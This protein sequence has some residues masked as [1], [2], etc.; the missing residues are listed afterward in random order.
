[1]EFDT[2]VRDDCF[3]VEGTSLINLR[4]TD[5]FYAWSFVLIGAN[6]LVSR[7]GFEWPLNA[8]LKGMLASV[9]Y[10]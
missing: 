5:L 8:P 4:P 6:P 2:I 10:G 7:P 3:Q 9:K 1:M